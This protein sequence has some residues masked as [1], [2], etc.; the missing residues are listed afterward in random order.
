MVKIK[1]AYHPDTKK[2]T[3]EITKYPPT[4]A[5]QSM[6]DDANINSIIKRNMNT[7]LL[8]DLDKLEMV[9]GQIT[10]DDLLTAHQ[11]ILAA[12]ESFMEIPSTIR[13]IFDNDAGK[14]IDYAT[15]PIN[16]KQMQE[17]KL[18]PPTIVEEKIIETKEEE[19]I[20]EK[21]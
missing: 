8:A 4:M 1:S 14:F 3:N 2:R 9:Y 16:L 15:N 5:K 10:Q 7:T 13:K 11:K 6:I 12:E 17:W 18:A 19:I 21:E 20:T